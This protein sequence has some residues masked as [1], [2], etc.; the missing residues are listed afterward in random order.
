VF[1]VQSQEAIDG[2]STLVSFDLST[3][4]NAHVFLDTQRPLRVTWQ[5]ARNDSWCSS[6]RG[7]LAFLVPMMCVSCHMNKVAVVVY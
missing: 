4:W 2:D 7:C 6:T 5:F 1:K 3:E